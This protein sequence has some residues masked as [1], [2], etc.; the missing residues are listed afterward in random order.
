[1]L[2][3]T[4]G[5]RG[6][7]IK[8]LSG[9]AAAIVLFIGTVASGQT[10]TRGPLIQ[11]PAALTTTMTIL[12]WTNVAGDST[13]EYGTTPAL[14]SSV[15]VPQAG[16]CEVDDPGECH[17]VPLTGL[18]PGTRY[19]YRLLTNGVQ[20]QATTYFTTLRDPSDTTEVF[21][22]VIGDWGQGTSGEQDVSNRQ[23]T[24]DPP[25]ILTVGDNTYPNGTQSE[26]DGNALAY[27][28]NPLRRALFY[29][30]LGNHDLNSVGGAGNYANSAYTKTFV[31]PTNSPQAERYYSFDHGDAHFIVLD[32]DSCCDGAQTAWLEAELATTTRK[33]KIAF[34]HHAPYSCGTGIFAIGSTTSVRNA[35]GPLFE[36]YGADV[37][38]T[39]H[40]HL[41]ERTKYMDDYTIGGGAGSDGLGTYYIMTGGGGATLDGSAN[42]S[43]GLPRDKFGAHC[44]WLANDC[45]AGTNSYCSISRYQYASVRINGSE[46]EVEAIDRN[47]VVFDTFTITKV[48]T[49]TPTSTATETP[50]PPTA[51]STNTFTRT[52]TRTPT[53][54]FTHT[55]TRTPTD[56]PT[57][58]P[59]DTATAT[60]TDTRTFTPTFTATVT[61]TFTLTR[62]PSHTFTPTLTRTPSNTPT[63]T[64]TRTFTPTDTP[65][66]TRTP[67]NT[68]SHTPTL[69]PV[70]TATETATVAAATPTATATPP[71]STHANDKGKLKV[72]NN[73]GAAGDEFLKFKGEFTL[74]LPTPA[75][76]PSTDGI[77]LQVSDENGVP[78]YT[79]T[80]PGGPQWRVNSRFTKWTYIDSTGAIGGLT[81]VQVFNR[82]RKQ[83]GLWKFAFKGRDGDFQVEV[84]EAPPRVSVAFGDASQ[85]GNGQCAT[86]VFNDAN[87]PT[88]RCSFAGIGR[89][90]SCR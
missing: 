57:V 30:A 26:L 11:N 78:L 21:F 58:T 4:W 48:P 20:V 64:P 8:L 10:I 76:D 35:W 62:T 80:I 89:V 41:Y 90:L 14:G 16:S 36:Q 75:I 24:A 38:F 54:T 13:V 47:G 7:V 40:D 88:L 71:C 85:L 59:T 63:R 25:L 39:G 5:V 27:Y 29:P 1:M 52:P 69:T 45:P 2:G 43:G 55:P 46:L 15:N 42:F 56:T 9:I 73:D 18:L 50:P 79:R 23:N 84:V 37:V 6:I 22:T 77:T 19:Y 66:S 72:S 87:A 67:T 86:L 28:V 53:A 12:W 31:L 17:R 82:A 68:R 60:P 51:T 34:L 44:Y 70:P 81:K 61:P 49:P 65:T 32:A 74:A 83:A 3:P 33:W